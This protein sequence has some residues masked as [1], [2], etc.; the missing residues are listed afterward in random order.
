MLCKCANE[1][2]NTPYRRLREGKLFQVE[3]EYFPSRS[4]RPQFAKNQAVAAHRAL[5]AV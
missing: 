3:T 5:L 1:A 2:C 4:P